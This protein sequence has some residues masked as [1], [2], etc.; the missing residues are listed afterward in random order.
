MPI[1]IAAG[2]PALA[3]GGGFAVTEVTTASFTRPA[4]ALLIAISMAFSET[5]PTLSGGSL[6]WTKQVDNGQAEIWTAPVTGSG[7][8]TVT[9]GNLSGAFGTAGAL[10]VVGVTGHDPIDPIGVAGTG[11]STNNNLTATG[12]TSTVAGSRGVFSAFTDE[13]TGTPTS[14]DTGF[15]WFEDTGVL[16]VGGIAAYKAANTASPGTDVTFNADAAGA[17]A[18]NWT[19][20]ALEIVPEVIVRQHTVMSRSAV[21]RAASW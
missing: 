17:G 1:E 7:S 11:D 14:T 4:G 5:A 19:W 16:D 9:L 20:A 8:M 21:H 13:A 10:K 2:T 18:A 3:S 12:Y 6:T 15:G